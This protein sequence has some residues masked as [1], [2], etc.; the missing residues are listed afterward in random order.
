MHINRV[1][2][3]IT[4]HIRFIGANKDFY[5]TVLRVHL[6]IHCYCDDTKC[7]KYFSLSFFNIYF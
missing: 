5:L 2:S 6:G 4:I 1:V 3:H 7:I